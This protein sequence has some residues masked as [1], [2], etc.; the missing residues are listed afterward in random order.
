RSNAHLILQLHGNS[1]SG[2][3]SD[4]QRRFT[5]LR[6]GASLPEGEHILL[7][8]FMDYDL[9]YFDHETCMG[10]PSPRMSRE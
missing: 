8:S 3:G 10:N 6:I 5:P 1:L 9:G 4:E 2:N 7:V